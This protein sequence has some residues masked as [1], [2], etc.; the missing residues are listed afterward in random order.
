MKKGNKREGVSI[1][2]ELPLIEA[3]PEWSQGML[4]FPG[5]TCSFNGI[6]YFPDQ[7]SRCIVIIVARDS[8]RLSMRMIV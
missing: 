7:G 4:G 8:H 6:S 3:A 5:F 2:K 1:K